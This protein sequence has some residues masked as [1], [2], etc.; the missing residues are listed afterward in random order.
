MKLRKG[1]EITTLQGVT[2]VVVEGIDQVVPYLT[3]AKRIGW[4]LKRVLI[5]S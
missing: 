4:K 5:L 3:W 2:F 1:W